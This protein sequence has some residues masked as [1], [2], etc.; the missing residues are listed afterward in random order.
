MLEVD[1]QQ[2][3]FSVV[4]KHIITSPRTFTS[5]SPASNINF[6]DAED[7]S[8]CNPASQ[9]L[10]T[11]IHHQTRYP[12]K[13]D[14]KENYIEIVREAR[15]SLHA[16]QFVLCD[17][18]IYGGGNRHAAASGRGVVA[19]VTRLSLSCGR[20]LCVVVFPSSRV[21]IAVKFRK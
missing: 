15:N 17:K 4:R 6:D 11:P 16:A 14:R 12:C 5:L 21:V 8:G 10:R 18:R 7:G 3:S 2:R 19:P 1:D 13:L 9:N 20:G